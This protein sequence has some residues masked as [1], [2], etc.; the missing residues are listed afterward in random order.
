MRRGGEGAHLHT[1]G[2]GGK[3]ASLDRGKQK[4]V[5]SLGS[6]PFSLSLFL[7]SHPALLEADFSAGKA[8]FEEDQSQGKEGSLLLGL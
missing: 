8:L 4:K 6:P 1:P 2:G 3:T 7:S 5:F